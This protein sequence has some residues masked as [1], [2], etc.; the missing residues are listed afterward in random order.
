VRGQFKLA[1]FGFTKIEKDEVGKNRTYMAGGT[2]TYGKEEN[3]AFDSWSHQE[4]N[5][6]IRRPRVR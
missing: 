5:P 2:Q 3:L 6:W 1:D 4:L